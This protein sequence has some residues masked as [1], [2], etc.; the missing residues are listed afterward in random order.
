MTIGSV[1]DLF[2]LPMISRY[3]R[4]S[5]ELLMHIGIIAGLLYFLLRGDGVYMAATPLIG[6]SRLREGSFV[7]H[8]RVLL[9][10]S[11]IS[12]ILIVLAVVTP[13]VFSF[14]TPTQNAMRLER[15]ETEMR[16][17]QKTYD[18]TDSE[19]IPERLALLEVSV[20]ELISTQ[21]WNIRLQYTMLI[22]VVAFL[23]KDIIA[24]I[25]KA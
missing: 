22:G 13:T 19:R 15:L 2:A 10:I 16:S 3:R 7:M 20:R 23:L 21:T 25:R 14:Q 4:D 9:L 6:H 12:Y 11:V 24:R 5:S 18:K 17:V 1:I 8:A